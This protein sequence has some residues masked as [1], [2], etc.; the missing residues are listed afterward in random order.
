MILTSEA[1]RD[2][3]KLPAV[4]VYKTRYTKESVDMLIL[5]FGITVKAIISLLNFREWKLVPDVDDLRTTSKMLSIYFD[6]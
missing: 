2:S 4:V 5:S 6:L 1:E 3:G